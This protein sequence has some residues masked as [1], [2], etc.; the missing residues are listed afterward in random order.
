MC[1]AVEDPVAHCH[2]AEMAADRAH[3]E[4]EVAEREGVE[5]EERTRVG[6]VG[7]KR[8]RKSLM[9]RWRTTG[10]RRTLV[11]EPP[12]PRLP[13]LRPRMGMT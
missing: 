12:R 5:A 8:R 1:Q 6:M 7:L 3:E 2:V 9:L 11:R 10:T 4:R 13:S